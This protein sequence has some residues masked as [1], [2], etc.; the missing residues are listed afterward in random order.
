M[1][2]ILR[3]KYQVTLDLGKTEVESCVAVSEFIDNQSDED[4]KDSIIEDLTRLYDIALKMS[5]LIPDVTPKYGITTTGEENSHQLVMEIFLHH[6]SAYE[7]LYDHYLL[8]SSTDKMSS[9]NMSCANLTITPEKIAQFEERVK[10]HYISRQKG[11]KCIV[12]CRE[13]NGQV[14]IVV[15]RGTH[16]KHQLIWKEK[17]Q[18]AETEVIVFRP[19]H[20][21]ILQ[22]DKDKSNL[23][24]KTSLWKD[25]DAYGNLFAQVILGDASQALRLDRDATYTLEPLQNGKFTYAVNEIIKSV[26]LLEV[27]MALPG[28]TNPTIL[29]NSSDINQTFASDLK[30]LNLQSGKLTSAKLLF[31][32]EIEGESKKVTFDITP[33]HSSNLTTKKYNDIISAYLK[34]YGVKTV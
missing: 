33:P 31:T 11:K 8:V 25:R 27:T 34:K 20:E 15:L 17:A 28:K 30:G 29:I 24:I 12:R 32:L 13:R 1:R 26:I 22:F 7:Y 16:K 10:A 21:D 14:L 23:T 6:K 2:S 5:N 4:V 3:Q 9:H 18:S 19:A